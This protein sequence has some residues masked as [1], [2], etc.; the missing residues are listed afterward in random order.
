[1]DT[2]QTIQVR[3]ALRQMAGLTAASVVAA[4]ASAT[5]VLRV[6][7]DGR[8]SFLTDAIGWLGILFFGACTV[9]FARLL[10]SL[11]GVVVTL[12]PLGIRDVRLGP[13]TI[14]WTAVRGLSTLSMQGQTFMIIDID[15][16]VVAHVARDRT[17]NIQ[18]S[19]I[20]GLAAHSLAVSAFG[21]NI[22]H[23]TL[24]ATSRAYLDRWG[25]NAP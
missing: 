7:D 14:P 13:E 21:L 8:S 11:S 3:G 5:I 2:S 4:A 18:R 1:M 25:R 24:I 12:S 19:P 17:A 20:E 9:V 16:E 6:L 15:P 22:R 23:D 10:L